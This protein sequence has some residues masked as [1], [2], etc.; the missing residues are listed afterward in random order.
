MTRGALPAGWQEGW[1]TFETGSEIE[2]RSASGK[3][4]NAIAAHVPALI[5]GDA[6]LS[7]STKTA[8]GDADNF[9][10]QTGAGRNIRFG[11]REHAMTAITNGMA[12]HGGVRPYASTFFIFSDY[13]RPSIR[14][15]AMNQ[16]PAIFLWTHDSIA[17]GEDG[18]THEPIEQLASLRAM[19]NM[20]LIRPADANETVAAWRV[21]MQWRTGPV[22]LV[23]SRQKLPVL[24]ETAVHA[25]AGV[26]RGAYVLADA[27]GGRPAIIL[28]ASGSEVQV[29]LAARELL[30]KEGI[31]ARVVSM[32]S[33]ELFESQERS[34]RESVL[35]SSVP[36]RVSI[37][38]GATLGWERYVGSAGVTFGIDRF[39][40]SAPCE[41]NLEK[42]GFT[43][44][45]VATIAKDLFN[46][47]GA[48]AISA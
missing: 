46:G 40:A 20:T 11:V 39:G 36:R 21:V 30:S 13:M 15:A 48:S 22:G 24:Q 4:L 6:D 1:P 32:P 12:Y 47:T 43:A 23:L 31:A 7:S 28:I 3:V 8:I 9:D 5:G 29:A 44:E 26:Q 37:E 42:F 14:L 16:L 45:A 19:P 25:A 10:G 27:E 41:V 18:P 33:W 38:A 2:T 34:Y 35:P 17:V